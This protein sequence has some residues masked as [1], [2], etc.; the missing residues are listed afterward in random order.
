M[1]DTAPSPSTDFNGAPPSPTHRLDGQGPGEFGYRQELDRTL[2][3]FAAFAAGFSYLSILTGMFQTF[4]L[5]YGP[6]GP[7]FFWTWPAVFLGQFLVALCFAELAAHYPLAGGIYQWSKYTGSWAVGWMTGWIYLASYLLALAAV[8]LA[9]QTTLPQIAPSAQVVPDGTKNAV[10]L[11]CVLILFSTVVNAGGIKWMAKINNIGVFTE[12]AGAVLLI[13]LLAGHAVRGPQVVFDTQGR[14]DGRPFGY[15]GPFLA[16]AVMAGFVMYG[17]DT[18][19]ALA[20][21][22]LEPRRR[23]PRAILQ[24]LAAA[25]GLG[26]LLMLF[27]LMAAP[28]LREPEL[29]RR[30]GGLPRI[31]RDA[32]GPYLGKLF[33]WDVIFAIVVCTLAVHA[34]A[35]RLIFALARDNH[36]P[37]SRALARVAASTR[38]PVVPALLVGGLAA[39]ILLVNVNAQK[40]IEAL[41]AV[42]IV[43]A[44]LAYLLVTGSLLYR[45]LRGWPGRGGG[46]PGVFRLGRWGIPLNAL[47]VVWG[48]AL[49]VNMGWPRSE[50]YGQEWYERYAALLF[51]A[52]LVG[53]GGAYHLVRKRR[54]LRPGK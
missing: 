33:L 37:F 3:P 13:V 18:A 9:L 54:Q 7:A 25:A 38:T 6:G 40:L 5:G 10:L 17:F 31:V 19:G 4:H 48:V 1:D 8:A 26:G 22:T 51:T 28:D 35:V 52:A 30:T 27:A 23:V 16:A 39:L 42:S 41:I 43:W 50:V 2:R 53:I 34:G 46:V 36:L 44:N 47:A 21:E 12:L 49:I 20:E 11:G 29:A 45:R 14:G 32:L 15:L 24:A